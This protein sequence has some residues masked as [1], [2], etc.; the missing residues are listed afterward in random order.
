MPPDPVG[1]RAQRHYDRREKLVRHRGPFRPREILLEKRLRRVRTHAEKA[2]PA[3]E[4]AHI[5]VPGFSADTP[6]EPGVIRIIPRMNRR[7]RT[8]REE[9]VAARVR[10][11]AGVR[12]IKIKLDKKI[13]LFL[14]RLWK[15]KFLSR[16][17]SFRRS[18][19]A[20]HA[21]IRV[22]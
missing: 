3:L 9:I 17:H 16:C 6:N 18:A 11:R 5:S 13:V 1:L 20:A 14:L 21:A 2:A 15:E 4:R 7:R 10:L 19:L 22:A 12:H 8:E